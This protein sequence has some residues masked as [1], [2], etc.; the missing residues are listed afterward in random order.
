MINIPPIV[1]EI[2]FYIFCTVIAIQIFYYLFFFTKLAFYKKK[3]KAVSMQH[4]V[5]IV[6]CAKDEAHNL[7]N[8]LPGILVQDYKTTHEVVVVNDNS[9][10]D[11]KYLLDEFK[12]SFKNLNHI[13]LSQEAKLIEGKKFP[14]SIGIKSA[15]HE[16]LLLTDADCVPSSENWLYTMQNAYDE[17]IEVVLGYG[18]YRK[19]KGI[20]NKLIRFET[21]HTAL[22]YFSYALAGLPYMGVGRNLSYKKEVFLRNKGFSSINTIPS[23]DD[24]LFINKVATKQNTA[25]VIDPEAFTLSNPKKTWSE[26]MNQKYRHYT[27]ARFYKPIHK[28]LLG[29]YSFS[30]F[31]IYPLL[32]VSSIFY[33]WWLALAVFG[34]RFLLQAII[35][36][37]AMK[38]LNEKDL[39]VWFL[40]FDLWMPLYYLFTIPAIW[41]SPKRTWS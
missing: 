33:C 21:F 32:A 27:T 20:L 31:C 39:W 7:A 15:K 10:D 37:K 2:I 36:F 13:E 16:I 4:P 23:G 3:T 22:Q 14:L 8:H 29:L 11:T 5:S 12:K 1:W 35:L 18:A 19:R 41:K 25:V 40:F 38:K 28:F 26:W 9:S 34:V 6:V 30:L 24:D 17:G